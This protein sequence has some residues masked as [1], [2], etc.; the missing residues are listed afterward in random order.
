MVQDSQ[1]A[2]SLTTNIQ[3]KQEDDP[4]P[5]YTNSFQSWIFKSWFILFGIQVP[6]PRFLFK[7]KAL[8]HW[9]EVNGYL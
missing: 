6:I 4:N 3:K 1:E 5:N 7:W 2:R 9:N 8:T